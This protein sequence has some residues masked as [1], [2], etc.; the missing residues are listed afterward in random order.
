[1]RR[2]VFF[3]F[4]GTITRKDSLLQFITFTHGKLSLILWLLKSIPHIVLYYIGAY[5]N[6][7]LKRDMLAFFYKGKNEQDLIFEGESFWRKKGQ[8]DIKG[9]ALNQIKMHKENGEKVVVVSASLNYW[10]APFCEEYGL[11]LICTRLETEQGVITGNYLTPNCY[12][13]EKVNRITTIYD[14]KEYDQVVAYGDSRGDKEMLDLAHQA[15]YKY[16]K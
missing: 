11:E 15:H 16:F 4:D 12:G 2:I 13:I 14:L 1:M 5:P 9:S 8:S 7:K 10:L 3:D 6:W